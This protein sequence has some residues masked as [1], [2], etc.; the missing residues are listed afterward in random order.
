MGGF[1]FECMYP[2]SRYPYSPMVKVPRPSLD[3]SSIIGWGVG[4]R[5]GIYCYRFGHNCWGALFQMSCAHRC[6]LTFRTFWTNRNLAH[7]PLVGL[8]IV[9]SRLLAC[10][11]VVWGFFFERAPCWPMAHGQ[12]LSHSYQNS[13]GEGHWGRLYPSVF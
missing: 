11:Y 6:E 12:L 2:S 3:S 4:S 10:M 13:D 5:C 9:A 8:I 1:S 7:E